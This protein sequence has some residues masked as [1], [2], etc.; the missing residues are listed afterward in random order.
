MVAQDE[1]TH[2]AGRQLQRDRRAQAAKTDDQGGGFKNF[3]L[4]LDTDFRQQDVAPVAH[5]LLVVHAD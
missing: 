1:P 4:A 2:P 5:K 3:L